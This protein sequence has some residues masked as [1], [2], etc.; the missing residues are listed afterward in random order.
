MLTTIQKFVTGFLAVLLL[1]SINAFP[2]SVFAHAG[3]EAIGKH[4]HYVV[5][6][7]SEEASP[8][9]LVGTS[10]QRK[11][12]H[13]GKNNFRNIFGFSS[14]LNLNQL[15]EHLSGDYMYIEEDRTLQTAVAEIIPN[16]PG[17]TKNFANI[18]RQWGL[19]KA[20]FPEAWATTKGSD[21][22]TVAIID[23]GLDGTH[24]DIVDSHIVDG[25][26]IITG[27]VISRKANSDDNGHGT[28]VTGV[29]GATTDN[30]TGIAGAAW[31]V[32]L[33]PV[34]A[35][36]AKG[37]GNSSQISE[38]IVWAADN[39]ADVINLSLG[40]I[41]FAHDTTLANAITYAFN[42]NVVIIAAAGNDVAVTGGNLDV[43]PVFP[44]CNDNGKNMIIGVTATD[45]NDLKP[46]FANY[47]KACVDVTAPGR[48]I[49]STIN[50]DPATNA[51][52]PDSY[53]YASGTS[54]A[55]PYVSGQAALLKS[56]FPFATN[57]QIRNRI[58][59]T[60]DQIDAL[61]LSQC[62]GQT[63]AGLLGSGRINVAKSLEEQIIRFED[64]DVVQIVGTDTLFYIN[65]GK[66]QQ[67]IPFVRNQR[68]SGI[69][70]KLA[71]VE[72][73]SDFSEGLFAAPLDGTLVKSLN[74][75]T[76]Y[77]ISNG[78]RL[79]VT[80]QVFLTRDLKFT[81]V[82][83]LSNIEVQ[84]WILGSFLT[85]PEGILV[86]TTTDPTVYWTV[87]GVLHPINF[88]YWEQRGLKVFPILF[89]PE[90][91]LAKYPK[92]DAYIL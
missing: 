10:V 6:L 54:L 9:A 51:T 13:A 72:E 50:R 73:L 82:K 2:Q 28:L 75:N 83:T 41:G 27:K 35:L 69:E 30:D 90:N 60:T 24:E 86:R 26:N 89:V 56:L 15:K 91:D 48:R 37:A 57:R 62:G 45:V 1:L 44:I 92:G 32:G 77:Y 55:V 47:G 53:A 58:I 33:M 88:G 17:F 12:V 16:D 22:V 23:T 38:A 3:V 71:T 7:K 21:D 70:P 59:A 25:F 4:V 43:E 42:K 64:G 52:A 61:N 34:K 85:P 81:D 49:L 8:L 76:V 36:N 66:K 74:D 65:G 80:Y 78:L 67:I 46:D 18:D 5:Q 40:G 68:F 31:R 79:P 87:G 39:G 11:F 20:K 14:S 19:V 84:S 29:I 63:C